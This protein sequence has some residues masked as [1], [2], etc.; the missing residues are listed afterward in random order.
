MKSFY[1]FLVLA[2][3]V[4]LVGCQGGTT[5]T[6][7]AGGKK[8]AANTNVNDAASVFK[9]LDAKGTGTISLTE[10]QAI[11]TEKITHKEKVT[12]AQAREKTFNEYATNGQ[13]NEQQFIKCYND[14]TGQNS[15]TNANQGTTNTP[16]QQ[17]NK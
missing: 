8:H 13:M 6:S 3:S 17:P 11:P 12:D 2:L 10:F 16:T 15:T 7:G 9:S 1:A 4:A 14:L 5:P